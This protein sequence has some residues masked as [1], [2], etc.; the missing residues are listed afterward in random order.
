MSESN[1][2]L[3]Y[4]HDNGS[5]NRYLHNGIIYLADFFLLLLFLIMHF[6]FLFFFFFCC[7]FFFFSFLIGGGSGD[8]YK[9]MKEVEI[10][11]DRLFFLLFSFFL[12]LNALVS[13]LEIKKNRSGFPRSRWRR[14][15]SVETKDDR[16]FSPFFFSFLSFLFF[17]FIL[18][19][20]FLSLRIQFQ[21]CELQERV[22]R[23]R[24]WRRDK[25][26][27]RETQKQK[28]ISMRK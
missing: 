17:F 15:Y 9:L 1:E 7:C 21:G 8:K 28:L 2:N 18:F 5:W 4:S 14:D 10:K 27:S 11:D 3:F 12:S 23:W 26:G 6:L 22:K 25:A 19:L 20:F 13:L 24:F 16:F